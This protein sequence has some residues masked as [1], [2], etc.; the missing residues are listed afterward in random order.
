VGAFQPGG[1]D[2]SPFTLFGVPNYHRDLAVANFNPSEDNFPDIIAVNPS[3]GDVSLL[4]GNGDGTFRPHRRFDATDA[5]LANVLG[6]EDFTS[7]PFALAVGDVNNDG[8]SDFVVV[9][10]SV[11]DTAQAAV[12]LGRA[13]G[14]FHAPKFF[15]LPD[16]EGDRTNAI[17][18]ADVN[19]DG[20]L[21]LVERDFRN[22]TSV[23]FGNGDGTFQ[24]DVDPIQR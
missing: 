23:M 16:R 9:D 10:S 18:L 4:L 6:D 1:P 19:G 20:N 2:G 21:D 3:S 5:A 8:N 15:I 17:R 13:D 22:G 14:T 24:T 12:R 7:V 11:V